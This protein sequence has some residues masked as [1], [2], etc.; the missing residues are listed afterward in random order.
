MICSPCI[1]KTFQIEANRFKIPD[2]DGPKAGGDQQLQDVRRLQ[3]SLPPLQPH[4]GLRHDLHRLFP[5]VLFPFPEV[6]GTLATSL[7]LDSF[8]FYSGHQISDLILLIYAALLKLL[9]FCTR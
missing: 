9:I 1:D 4:S 7:Y 5:P 8:F 6:P 3:P 2:R